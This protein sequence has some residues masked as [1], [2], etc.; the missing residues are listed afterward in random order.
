MLAM[1]IMAIGAYFQPTAAQVNPAEVVKGSLLTELKKRKLIKVGFSTFIPWAMR[2][3]KGD[4]I[5]YEIDVANKL[6]KDSGWKTELVPMAWDGLIPSVLY[7]AV[8]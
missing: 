5:G 6:G 7:L 8:E 2:D 1:V 3:L 4:I